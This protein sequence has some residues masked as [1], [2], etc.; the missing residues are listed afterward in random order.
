MNRNYLHPGER[1]SATPVMA[2]AMAA[3]DGSPD[4]SIFI[5]DRAGQ[6]AFRQWVAD[7][8]KRQRDQVRARGLDNAD[9]FGFAIAQTSHVE[10][11][12]QEVRYSDIQYPMLVPVDT[13]A[14]S[15][16]R[17]I[18]WFSRDIAG[19]AEWYAGAANGMPYA[20]SWREKKEVTVEMAAI[21]YDYNL[22][23]IN[24]AA[25]VG[26][27]IGTDRG[28]AANR[29]AE[30]FI[31]NIVLNGDADKGWQGL[32]NV[33]GVEKSNDAGNWSARTADQILSAIN[34]LLGNLWDHSKRVELADTLLLPPSAYSLLAGL[35][36]N[37]D[38]MTV[39]QWIQQ[40]NL[41]TAMTGNQLMIRAVTGLENAAASNRGRAIAYRRAP[42]VL[43]L[44][45]PMPHTFLPVWQKDA[46]T[47]EVPGIMRT[48]GLEVRRPDAMRYL[49]NITA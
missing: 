48:G 47:F 42:D 22:E 36:L 32:F 4:P 31:E 25:M 23:E 20:E 43:K 2:A 39:L 45:L 8:K 18:T 12:V 33:T 5:G 11:A 6:H 35:R 49:D 1:L 24:Q 41:Y 17:S 29:A 9:P 7:A 26:Q 46:L 19:K 38:G 34:N 10:L 40:A 16:A 14:N 13:S 28:I 21:G 15:W 30:E 3:A 37:G 44:H 27:N